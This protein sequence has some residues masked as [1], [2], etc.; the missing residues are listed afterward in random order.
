LAGG[1]EAEALSSLSCGIVSMSGRRN[2]SSG[3][4]GFDGSGAGSG[5]MVATGTASAGLL[6]SAGFAGS[7]V[8]GLNNEH[9]GKHARHSAT[10]LLVKNF[11]NVQSARIDSNKQSFSNRSAQGR[12]NRR[13]FIF[14]LVSSSLLSSS[15]LNLETLFTRP[16][17]RGM[18]IRSADLVTSASDLGGCPDWDLPEFALI[19][20]SNVGKSSLINLLTGRNGLAK[21]SATPGKTR[22][23]NFFLI[24]QQWSLVDL[25]GYGFAKVAKEEAHAFNE[26][27]GNYIGRR[28]CLRCVLV[29]I[30]SRHPPQRI[31]MDF[32]EW[33]SGTGVPFVIVFTKADKQSAGKTRANAAVFREHVA[34]RIGV[35]PEILVSSAVSR[36]GRG[37]VMKFIESRLAG[38]P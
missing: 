6:A 20:R 2:P 25:P 22:L 15:H 33:L 32:I 11:P 21:V 5:T 31:D 30:D 38:N 18:Q 13:F 17:L 24:N 19:G 36:E 35:E 4:A 3:I 16:I 37:D 14:C 7:G 29:L 12:R 8:F 9:A 34:A 23:M 28:A 1:A 10:M 26:R 27:S